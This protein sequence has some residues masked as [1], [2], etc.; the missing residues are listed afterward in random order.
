MAPAPRRPTRDPSL[1]GLRR[2]LVDAGGGDSSSE[3]AEAEKEEEREASL[4]KVELL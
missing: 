1:G 4:K 2:A 3:R